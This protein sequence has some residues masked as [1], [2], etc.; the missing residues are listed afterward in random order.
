[1]SL[2][3]KSGA[4]YALS[5]N[6]VTAARPRSAYRSRRLSCFGVVSG[7]EC[8]WG[9]GAGEGLSFKNVLP[10]RITFSHEDQMLRADFFWFQWRQPWITMRAESS[11]SAGSCPSRFGAK[12]ILAG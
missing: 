8:S 7:H 4:Q 10:P 3:S 2:P 5:C 11:R 12:I 1:M 6:P 9:W